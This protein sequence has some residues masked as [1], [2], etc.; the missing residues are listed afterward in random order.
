MDIIGINRRERKN[1]EIYSQIKK[2]IIPSNIEIPRTVRALQLA[3]KMPS[4]DT[5]KYSNRYDKS[6]WVFMLDAPFDI[7][8]VCCKVMK[9]EPFKR[10]QKQT[11]RKP[12]IA[13]LACESFL[14]QSAWVKNGCNAFNS[15]E[16]KSNPLSFW[17][18]QDILQYIKTRD[19]KIAPVYGKVVIDHEGEFEGQISFSELLGD[20]E[21]EK[22]KTTGCKRTGCMFC[23]YG[24]HL[25]KPGEGRFI[26]MKESHPKIYD[27]IMRPTDKGGLNYKE[28]IDW[29]NENGDGIHIDY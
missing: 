12:I 14:R 19:I 4:K 7:S 21:K 1:F 3:G 5:S 13:T 11:G 10:Y 16:P 6:R 28:I 18:E 20:T 23:G 29:I 27:Y 17:T 15:K 9:K 8:N 22:L 26:K 24:C 2:G 25:E